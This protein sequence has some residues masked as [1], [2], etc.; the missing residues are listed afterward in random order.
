MNK[1]SKKIRQASRQMASRQKVEDA[2][3]E[4]GYII[5]NNNLNFA[6]CLKVLHKVTVSAFKSRVEDAEYQEDLQAILDIA[7][8]HLTKLTH[9]VANAVAYDGD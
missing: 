7:E 9:D 5:E 4:F 2:F 6:E 1:K 8:E 3:E